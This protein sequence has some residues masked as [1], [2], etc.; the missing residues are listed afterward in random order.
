MENNREVTTDLENILSLINCASSYGFGRDVFYSGMFG[1]IKPVNEQEI[2]DYAS[3]FLTSEMRSK[4]Y[5]E[6]D[7]ESAIEELTEL[8]NRY[9]K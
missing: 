3:T 2:Q 8:N 1:I 4:G 7:Y 5:T 6:E 9:G